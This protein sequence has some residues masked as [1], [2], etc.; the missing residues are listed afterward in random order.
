MSYKR[1]SLMQERM[2]Q[3][4]KSILNSARNLISE[5]GF[6]DAQIQTIAEQAGVS[7]GL[8]YRYFDN[9]SQVL[10]E[11]LSEAINTELLVIDAITES[12]LP[13]ERKLHKAVATF[14][15][16]ALNSP[17][18]AYSLMFEPVDSM[19]EHERFR[20]KQLIKQSVIKILADG[21]ASGEFVLED[22]NTTALCVVG[23][24]TFVVVEPLDPAQNTK[25]DQQH[26]D[27]FSKQIA[28][29]C[30]DAVRKK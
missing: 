17:Q 1:S 3:N 15:K 7:S 18:L 23:A 11:V 16:R 28:D 9:K 5:G 20:V 30:V 10:I 22:L 25:F 29:F 14:V 13:A 19:V 6:K 2:E 26:K 24:M 27:Y 4:R 8:V 12:D 21:N